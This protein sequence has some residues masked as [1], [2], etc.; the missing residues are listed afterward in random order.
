MRTADRA[1]IAGGVLTAAAAVLHVAIIVGGPGWYRFFGAGERMAMFAER[2]S[3]Y[4]GL[5]TAGIA[6]TLALFALYAFSGA[7]L[8]R[9]LPFLRPMLFLIAAIFTMRGVLGVPV[10]LLADTRYALELRA[11][12]PFMLVTSA[13]CV[14][15]GACYAIGAV[16]RQ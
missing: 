5:L 14:V 15:L 10:V 11:R 4:P 8:V 16:R 9:T 3:R 6:C 12:M 1:L 7:G 2:G 13:T